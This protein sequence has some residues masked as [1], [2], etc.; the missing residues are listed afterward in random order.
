MASSAESP[1]PPPVRPSLHVQM[2]SYSEPSPETDDVIKSKVDPDHLA[3]ETAPLSPRDS[4]EAANRLHDDLELLRA[5][6]VVST[7]ERDSNRPRSKTR[8]HREG[9][10]DAFNTTTAPTVVAAPVAAKATWLT[11]LWRWLKK[12]PRVLR[13]IL[14]AIP[15]AII[16][17]VPV[18]LDLF[19]YDRK[20]DPV[21]GPGGV[22]LL[23]F[24]IWLEVLWLTLWAARIATS[25]LPPIVAFAADT[26]GSTNHK[27]W[28]DIGR[29][30]EFPTALF[31]W[32]LAVL[33]SYRPILNHRVVDPDDDNKTP[34]VTWIDVVFK[35]IIALFVLATLN[36]VEKVLIKWIA[37][38]F[39]LRTY[40]HRIRENTLHIEYLVTLYAYAKTRL[41]EQD[42]V[43]DSPSSRRGSGQYPSPL[44]NI[45]NNA[46][47][48]WSKV[49]NA[50]NR[51][52]GDFTG[53]KFLKGNH[54]R[55]V[56]MELLRNS[57]SSYTLARVF[58]RTFVQPEKSTVAVEDLFPAFPAQEDA[59]A[60][61]GVFDKDLN[62]DVSMEELEM[63]CNEI[64]LEKKAIAASL[65]DLD[66]VIKKLDEVFMFLIVVIVIIV[67]ISIISN[68]AAAALTSTGTV[69]LGLSWLL[70]ATAQE[71][72]QS[73][74][75]VFVKHPFDVGD[76][77]TIYGNTGSMMK[78]DDY[79]VLEVSL[80]YTEFK[81][82]E[83]H[84]VQA[85]NSVLNTLFILN[86]RRSQGLADPINLKLRFGTSEAQIEELKSRMLDFCL[87]NKR[88]YAPR[89]ISEVQTI[90]EVSSITMNIIFFHKSN[91]Q[92]ELLRLN[93][94]NK[95]AVELMHQM[96]DMGLETPHLVQPGGMRDMPLY[97]TQV[98]PPPGYQVTAPAPA[99]A[100]TQ[101][102]FP[103][104][105]SP[106]M[107]RRA[108]SRAA[109]VEAGM[110]FQDI[111]HNRRPDSS[112]TRLASI[113]QS[114]REEDEDKV[115]SMDEQLNE[116][117]EKRQSLDSS[118]SRRA[119]R[120]R[121]RSTNRGSMSNVV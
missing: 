8:S 41:E 83:G 120:P 15:P 4:R 99:P 16:I 25:V 3:P 113:R 70:Q 31:L 12:F 87:Q 9:V 76:R 49:G 38:S 88:D 43:W 109:V 111:Y 33:V 121:S 55:K 10:E 47:H 37:T 107:R 48:V 84:V 93:R 65:K 80:L 42:P 67:F 53:R 81:K 89:I 118:S 68:S 28:R 95:F 72:L 106:T 39:H 13:Y 103:P 22:Q 64:H 112:M 85:P 115:T 71:F 40:S 61:F 90:D 18:F 105:S 62:G 63:V 20:G 7:Q 92:N 102:S 78:G 114:P 21:G 57:E 74:I 110:D 79:Y 27:K 45:Q 91:Y 44:K 23:W 97:W 66:S 69:I 59:E 86:Q 98:Q 24:G 11:K 46:R 35:V 1:P 36:L 58:Y 56:V 6:R 73:I 94:H 52:A 19:A 5:E 54:P 32:L 34:Y 51:M 96:H 117:T 29:Q 82:M 75:F 119:W 2:P 100:P 26:V 50:A 77:V 104:A 30:L 116:K 14:Y 101:D 108:N 60:C 17:L